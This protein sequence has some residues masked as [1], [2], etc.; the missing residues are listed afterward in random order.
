MNASKLQ[1]I[2]QYGITR[3]KA[4]GIGHNISPDDRVTSS[5]VLFSV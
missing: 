4:G 3:G 5:A 2:Q 1:L